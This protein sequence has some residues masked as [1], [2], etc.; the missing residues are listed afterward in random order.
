MSLTEEKLEKI[1]KLLGDERGEWSKRIQSLVKAIKEPK[2]LAESQTHML[3]YRHMIVDK[4]MEMNILT[5]Q[6]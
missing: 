4:I 5:F 3:S 2:E 6:K 1:E